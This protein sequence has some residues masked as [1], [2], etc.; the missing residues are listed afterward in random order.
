M[1]KLVTEASPLSLTLR[2]ETDARTA[3][4]RGLAE[5]MAGLS[6]VF[7]SG[8]KMEFK[9]VLEVWSEPEFKAA[10]P[11]AA[12]QAIGSGEYT[13][14]SMAPGLVK[15]DSEQY[16]LRETCSYAIDFVVTVFANDPKERMGLVAMLEDAFNPVEFM[17]GFWLELPHYHGARAT[18]ALKD[19]SYVDDEDSADSRSR[20][21]ELT[22]SG[23]VPVYR[24][25]GRPPTMSVQVDVDVEDATD[26]ADE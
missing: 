21:A 3:M 11:S 23:E 20:V 15:L 14:Q 24:V 22:L 17:F 1:T 25:I 19:S 13:D 10:Y 26:S 7:A 12:V 9:Q 18:F 6:M 8:R 16:A 5:Y 2:R 4:A